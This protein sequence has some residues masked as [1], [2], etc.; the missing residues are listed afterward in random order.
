[1]VSRKNNKKNN[2]QPSTR[3]TFK[4]INPNLHSSASLAKERFKRSLS[5]NPADAA[6]Q[7]KLREALTEHED[8]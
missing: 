1:M 8:H 6:E 4:P 7:E 5:L 3:D 2:N